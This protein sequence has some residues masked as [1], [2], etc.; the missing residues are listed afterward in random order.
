MRGFIPDTIYKDIPPIDW[1]IEQVKRVSQFQ[2]QSYFPLHEEMQK[3]LLKKDA[4][5]T[6]IGACAYRLVYPR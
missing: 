5:F 1:Q 6:Q 4:D 2:D 3:R